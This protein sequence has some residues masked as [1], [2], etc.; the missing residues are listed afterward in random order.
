MKTKKSDT[1]F[2]RPQETIAPFA[3]DEQVA[4]VFPDMLRRSIPGYATSLNMIE[5]F[6]SRLS[7]PGSRIYDLGSSLGAA[8]QAVCRGLNARPV[9]IIA[10]DN[11]PAMIRRSRGILSQEP[12]TAAVQL[13]CADIR[14]VR[15]SNASLVILNYTL[16]FLDPQERQPLL[17]RI[18]KGLLPG[19]ALLLAEKIAFEDK[20]E[21]SFQTDWYYAF[22]T[23]NGYSQMEISQKRTALENVL[24]PDTWQTH[25]QRLQRA[26]FETV[27]LWHRFFRFASM[28]AIK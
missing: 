9:Q 1:V 20:A 16:Q 4:E 18:Y 2:S 11:S 5:M 22:K 24:I 28:I 8:T 19:G 14:S 25:R 21:Q 6:A 15:I 26:G 13:V 12:Q 17:D 23:Y 3:F 27:H 10:V 7:K